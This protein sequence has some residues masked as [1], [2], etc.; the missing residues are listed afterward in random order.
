MKKY[1]VQE[2]RILAQAA[3]ACIN[4]HVTNWMTA[5]QVDPILKT[6]IECISDWKVQDVKHLLGDDAET[7]GK[8]ILQE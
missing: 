6:M 1:I 4:L 3:Q 7:E 5:Q 8:T 2:T